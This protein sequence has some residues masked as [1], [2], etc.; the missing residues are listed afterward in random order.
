[1]TF[2]PSSVSQITSQSF[3][4]LEIL[5]TS[6][7]AIVVR[8]T[9]SYIFGLKSSTIFPCLNKSTNIDWD[10]DLYSGESVKYSFSKEQE[11]P[12]LQAVSLIACVYS[13]IVSLHIS[14]KFPR[15][16]VL[17]FLPVFFSTVNSM[18]IPLRST[19]HGK[20]TSLPNNLWLRAITSIILYWATAPICQ[21]PLG[22][23]GGVS[24]TNISFL[25]S[26]LNEYLSLYASP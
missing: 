11:R 20:Y 4:D 25:E 16:K 6:A 10:T 1:M 13:S 24:I 14:M 9:G 22:Y 5:W 17:I 18:F 7:S 15:S 21:V 23:G 19:P 3:V 2:S 26:G 8:S 12:T